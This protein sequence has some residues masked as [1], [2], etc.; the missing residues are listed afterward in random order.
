MRKTILAS[1]ILGCALPTFADT[2]IKEQSPDG[3]TTISIKGDWARMDDANAPGFQLWNLKTGEMHMVDPG[4]RT[5][6]TVNLRKDGAKGKRRPVKATIKKLGKG[7]KIAGYPTVEYQL[8]TSSKKCGTEYVSATAAK[9]PDIRRLLENFADLSN[10]DDL[11][12]GPMGTV[13]QAMMDPCDLAAQSFSDQLPKLGMPLK[14]VD[15]SGNVETEIVKIDTRAKLDKKQF[16]LPTGYKRT[17]IEQEMD[18]AMKEMQQM[19]QQIPPEMQ[20]M[21]QKMLNKPP[22]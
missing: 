13:A 20:Q 1:L 6:M 14:T 21:M 15:A 3:S 10:L 22:Q 9:S 7:P 19:M 4:E 16:T 17:S 18:N 2:V 5:I 8:S 12:P 11:I